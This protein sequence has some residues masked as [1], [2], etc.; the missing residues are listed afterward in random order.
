[1]AVR[2]L[3]ILMVVL[4]GVS[5]LAAALLPSR[6]PD[7]EDTE[8]TAT[9]AVATGT[10]TAD[11]TA[12]PEPGREGVALD[13]TITVGGEQIPVVKP[14]EVGDQLSL[15]VKCRCSDLVE[16]PALGLVES[17]GPASPAHFD[18]LPPDEGSYGI[19]LID[20]DKVVARIEVENGVKKRARGE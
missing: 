15:T 7:D 18:L 4:L 20:A 9:E 8:S 11:E 19:R 2:R 3:L 10:T 16:I 1:M 14:V 5:A 12:P 6:P 13:A 17:V